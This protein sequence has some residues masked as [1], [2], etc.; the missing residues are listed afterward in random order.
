MNK[1]ISATDTFTA[2]TTAAAARK[3]HH[4]A[5]VGKYQAAGSHEALRGL[6]QFLNETGMD[7]SIERETA[8]NTDMHQYLSIDVDAIG[9][10]CDLAVVAMAPYLAWVGV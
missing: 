9:Q 10:Q 7:V 1:P 4:V 8:L 5:L 2:S 6:A 3:F